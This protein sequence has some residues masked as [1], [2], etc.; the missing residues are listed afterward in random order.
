MSKSTEHKVYHERA[1]EK[2]YTSSLN[3]KIYVYTT[4]PLFS[5]FS[6]GLK[7]HPSSDPYSSLGYVSCTQDISSVAMAISVLELMNLFILM[8]A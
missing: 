5:D 2:V 1:V 3:K 6:F 4:M 7:Q 8:I